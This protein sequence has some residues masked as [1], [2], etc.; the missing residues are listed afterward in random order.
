MNRISRKKASSEYIVMLLVGLI[1]AIGVVAIVY[2]LFSSTIMYSGSPTCPSQMSCPQRF[3]CLGEVNS[4]AS[5][6]TLTGGITACGRGGLGMV[7]SCNL[8]TTTSISTSTSTSTSSTSLYTTTPTITSTSTTT[9][10]TTTSLTSTQTST[11]TS[12]TTLISTTTI[13]PPPS[14]NYIYC[15]GTGAT[16]PGTQTY[17][18]PI[19]SSGIGAWIPMNSYPIQEMYS[20]CNIDKPAGTTYMYCVGA[21][22]SDAGGNQTYYAPISS[23]G[24]GGA[25]KAT[26]PYPIKTYEI[27]CSVY[28]HY[29]YCVGGYGSA[30]YYAPIDESNG[31]L[32]WKATTSYPTYFS[33]AGCS[34]FNGYI[35]CVGGAN[36]NHNQ[37][38][39]APVSFSGIGTWTATTSYPMA[40]QG[41][42]C[43]VYNNSTRGSYLYC[44][45]STPLANSANVF[46]APISSTGVG[47]W[48]QTA[49]YPI[50]L[51]ENGCSISNS[52]LYC[53]G[54][55]TNPYTQVFYARASPNGIVGN[56]M[57][58]TSYP[59]AMN[60][61]YCEIP[62]SGGGYLGG[63]GP[64]FYIS[65]I[66]TTIST[67]TLTTTIPPA[68]KN[69]NFTTL[70]GSVLNRAITL[71]SPSNTKALQSGVGGLYAFQHGFSTVNSPQDSPYTAA[72]YVPTST[73]V[74]A[75]ANGG[76][77]SFTSFTASGQ[78]QDNLLQITNAQF[79]ALL[80]NSGSYG[81]NEY[82][83]LTGFPV[84]D[85][86]TSPSVQN[87]A[88]IDA[89][90]AYQVT[91]N[92][93]I[94]EPY[95]VIGGGTGT[96][97]TPGAN[98]VNNA[99]IQ[100]LG[101]NWT[102]VSYT[103]PSGIPSSNTVAVHGGKLTL[104]SSSSSNTLFLIDGGVFNIT[105]DPGWD[106]NLLWVNISGSG[107]YTDLQS[108]IIYNTTP[109]TLTPGQS[110]RFIQNPQVYKVLFAG[111]TNSNNYDALSVSSIY[112]SSITYQNLGK[113]SNGLGTGYI[114][115]I[116]EPSQ[117][118]VLTSQIPNAFS[119]VGQMS[120][121]A[122]YLL[123]PYEINEVVHSSPGG[124]PVRVVLSEPWNVIPINF[125]TPANPLIVTITGYPTSTSTAP[126]STSLVFTSQP[127]NGVSLTT[128]INFYN[129]TAIKLS[130]GLPYIMIATYNST[131]TELAWLTSMWYYLIYPVLGSSYYGAT[132]NTNIVYNQYNGQPT[133]V[134]SFTGGTNLAT[135]PPYSFY[136]YQMPEYSVPGSISPQDKFGFSILNSTAGASATPLFQ[137]NYSQALTP[138]NVTYVSGQGVNMNAGAGFISERGSKVA[139]ISPTQLTFDLSKNIDTLKFFVGSANAILSVTTSTSTTTSTTSTTIAG[140]YYCCDVSGTMCALTDSYV[141]TTQQT[142]SSGGFTLCGSTCLAY[143][144]C[145]KPAT[146]TSTTST[147]TTSTSFTT[148]IAAIQILC[149]GQ[150]C[151]YTGQNYQC[152]AG[153]VAT[154]GIVCSRGGQG[155]TEICTP[156]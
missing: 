154:A 145:N 139:A 144:D 28:N 41:G 20:G 74:V 44:V 49:M 34:I 147:S 29:I 40:V 88:L 99:T 12:T 86:Q 118:L 76:G 84:Y 111:D 156:I 57:A 95:Y 117:M 143:S 78:T 73:S 93:P 120:N 89:G 97:T 56:W 115:N 25:W 96:G 65:T 123:T 16:L 53:V 91:F 82:L 138:N 9:L 126:S 36:G 129:I 72:G 11:S 105:T 38:Y 4:C 42:G 5:G 14:S 2:Q 103:L 130:R 64:N 77:V 98:A 8:N 63:G 30:S 75:T 83:W 109:V 107:H 81:E 32:A 136:S 137:I 121:Q 142:C 17:Y 70:I 68:T 112:S 149:P 87:F 48:T 67:S 152:A 140:V 6:C 141:C 26:T 94:H 122:T 7:W 27:S 113:P 146:S 155:M 131:G 1:V 153:C 45:G 43:S 110:Y 104:K 46:Y 51:L 21:F 128:P 23:T 10:Y 135:H 100:L 59:I 13:I 15:V 116:T 35:Y 114:S 54:S 62:G 148:S 124:T 80:G 24:M 106:V 108:I 133:T 37:V 85:Q 71:G 119:Y 127:V 101:Q 69:Y 61:A 134:F 52:T 33:D 102:I 90:G 79:P 47:T 55:G 66:T 92:K 50:G 58:T 19:S 125:I 151:V 132:S 31:I 18:A 39:Y 150:A 22:N 3:C 60:R